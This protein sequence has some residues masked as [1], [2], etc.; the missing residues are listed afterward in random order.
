MSVVKLNSISRLI[1]RILRK[2]LCECFFISK[3]SI[4]I[5]IPMVFFCVYMQPGAMG[6][7]EVKFF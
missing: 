6:E 2:G 4:L 3:F 5:Q 1:P 7:D